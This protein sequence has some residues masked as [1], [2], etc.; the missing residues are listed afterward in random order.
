MANFDA[1]GQA[2]N[3]AAGTLLGPKIKQNRLEDQM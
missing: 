2:L 1:I 3:Q